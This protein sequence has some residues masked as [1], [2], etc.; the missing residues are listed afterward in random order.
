V[1]S[2]YPHPF[3]LQVAAQAAAVINVA[4]VRPIFEPG[5]VRLPGERAARRQ[6]TVRLA[7]TVYRD[8]FLPVVGT[9]APN[10]LAE[11]T[12]ITER[13]GPDGKRAEVKLLEK[14]K[15]PTFRALYRFNFNSGVVGSGLRKPSFLKVKTADDDPATTASEARYRIAEIEGDRRVLPIF[16]VSVYLVPVDVQGPVRWSERLIPNPTIGF[17]FSNPADDVFLGFNHEVVRNLQFFWG[18]HLGKVG[19]LSPRN[20]VSEDRD[21]TA[22]VTHDGRRKALTFGFTFNVNVVT[23]IFKSGAP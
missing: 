16:A 9:F 13:T 12:L 10:D 6:D 19:K 21:A 8:L 18:L 5:A 17:A 23:K 2:R 22:P 4:P 20:D 1:Q 11:V 14:A 3:T 7:P 15:M